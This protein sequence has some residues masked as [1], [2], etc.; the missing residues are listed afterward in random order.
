MRTSPNSTLAFV[1]GNAAWLAAGFLLSFGSGFGQTFFLSFFGDKFRAEFGLSDGDWGQLYMAATVLSGLGVMT[2]GPLAD[3]YRARDIALV[4]GLVYAACAFL[5]AASTSLV[6][7]ALALLG[8]RFCGQGL[9]SHL[10]QTCMAR[11]YA[12]NRGR[13]LALAGFG[14]P[15]SEALFPFVAVFVASIAGWRGAWVAAGGFILLALLPLLGRLLRDERTPSQQVEIVETAG[16]SGRHWSRAEMLRHWSFYALIPAMLAPGFVLTV[17]FFQMSALAESRGWS[18]W[19]IASAY[20]IFSFFSVAAAAGAGLLIDRFSARALLPYY[21][22]PMAAGLLAPAYAGDWALV[23]MMPLCGLCAGT[24][25][26]AHAAALTE[27]Y[28]SRYIGGIKS[29]A[30]AMMVFSTAL[31]PGVTG[32]LLDQNIALES[33]FVAMAIYSAI[34]SLLLFVV[35]SRLAPG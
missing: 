17:L 21:L 6:W 23:I 25:A 20:P 2:L 35:R 5:L 7:F 1:R 31:G 22:L 26:S 18:P 3:R 11:W 4:G 34:A 19:Q 33:Q 13:A 12:G 8:L 27:I 10:S 30:H 32:E 15:A 24:A 29:F 16:R 14:Y 9:F 28:G